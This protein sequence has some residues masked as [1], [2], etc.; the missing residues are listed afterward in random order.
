MGI[1]LMMA[2]KQLK[3]GL[4]NFFKSSLTYWNVLVSLTSVSFFNRV[5]ILRMLNPADFIR[6]EYANKFELYL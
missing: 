1:L 4:R 5:F 3:I 6:F 2:F